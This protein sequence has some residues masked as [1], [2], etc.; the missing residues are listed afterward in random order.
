VTAP[1]PQLQTEPTNEMWALWTDSQEMLNRTAQRV[2]DA[3][4]AGDMA[5][6]KWLHKQVVSVERRAQERT[7]ASDG[8]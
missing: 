8:E 6:M 3:W 2:N 7:P 1:E 5:T 4:H